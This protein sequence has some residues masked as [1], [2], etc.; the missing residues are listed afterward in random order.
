MYFIFH[1][2]SLPRQIFLMGKSISI[3]DLVCACLFSAVQQKTVHA[4]TLF[5]KRITTGKQIQVKNLF[6]SLSRL[7]IFQSYKKI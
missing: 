4:T 3:T 6:R 2:V 5:Q 7:G 1:F